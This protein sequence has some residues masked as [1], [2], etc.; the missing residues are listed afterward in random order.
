M[1]FFAGFLEVLTPE[2]IVF[3]IVIS[4]IFGVGFAVCEAPESMRYIEEQY[5]KKKKKE[6]AR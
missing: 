5:H 2:F 1:D 4:V 6:K 3:L